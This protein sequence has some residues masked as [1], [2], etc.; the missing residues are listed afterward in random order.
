MKKMLSEAMST[1]KDLR[2]KMKH[3]N[4][5]R[6]EELVKRQIEKKKKERNIRQKQNKTKRGVNMH[7][8]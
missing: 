3:R 5:Q 2:E 8:N 7:Y 4:E 1:R 6:Q